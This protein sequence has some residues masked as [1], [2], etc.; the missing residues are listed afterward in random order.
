[1]KLADYFLLSLQTKHIYCLWKIRPVYSAILSR[2]GGIF[3]TSAL[4]VMFI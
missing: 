4:I 1:M 3:L 2:K